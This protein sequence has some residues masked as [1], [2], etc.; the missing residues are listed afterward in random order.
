MVELVLQTH[1]STIQYETT[2]NLLNEE[3]FEALC[4][5]QATYCH[6][7]ETALV[8]DGKLQVATRGD[9]KKVHRALPYSAK[10][11]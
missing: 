8:R 7:I 1:Y 5:S 6:Y 9:D 3:E 2:D 10:F 11:W 4:S